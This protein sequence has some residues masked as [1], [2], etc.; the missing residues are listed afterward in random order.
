METPTD[1]ASTLI[2]HDR[3]RRLQP[4]AS[5]ESFKIRQWWMD[6]RFVREV[7][8]LEREKRVFKREQLEADCGLENHAVGTIRTG[9]RGVSAVNIALL[10]EKYR[11][12][13]DY[14]MFGVRNKELSGPHIPGIGSLERYEKF[15]YRYQTAAKWKIGR[16]PETHKEYYPSD[17]NNELWTPPARL[18]VGKKPKADE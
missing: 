6:F 13:K 16:Q 18:S 17:P 7:E 11:G 9:M 3:G 14:I 5:K 15:Y 8:R 2:I 1:S 4:V 10:F 12:D